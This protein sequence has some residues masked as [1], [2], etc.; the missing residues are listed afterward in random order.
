MIERFC[1]VTESDIET[2]EKIVLVFVMIA[3]AIMAVILFRPALWAICKLF[4]VI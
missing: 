1:E 3:L 2:V 4:G